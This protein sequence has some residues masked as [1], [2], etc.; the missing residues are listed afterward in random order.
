MR[1]YAQVRNATIPALMAALRTSA[2]T[3]VAPRICWSLVRVQV[4]DITLLACLAQSGLVT[5]HAQCN[6]IRV[7]DNM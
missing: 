4:S 3:L 6:T 5:S 2:A 7:C 1:G